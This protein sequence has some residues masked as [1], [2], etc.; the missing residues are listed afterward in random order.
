MSRTAQAIRPKEPVL[1]FPYLPLQ[2]PEGADAQGG[3]DDLA[4]APIGGVEPALTSDDD[5]EA[6]HFRALPRRSASAVA[7]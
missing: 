7:V 3:G 4:L 1:G 5:G 2:V 6:A